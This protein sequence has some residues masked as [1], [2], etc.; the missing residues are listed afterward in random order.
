MVSRTWPLLQRLNKKNNLTFIKAIQG[1]VQRRMAIPKDGKLDFYS[2]AAG[3]DGLGEDTLRNSEL[4]A[5]AVFF[6]PAGKSGDEEQ[7]SPSNFSLIFAGGTT[8]S[9]A[10]SAIFFYLSR[11]S[12]VYSRLATEIRTTFSSGDEI[13]SGAQL[14]GCKYLRATIDET[15]RVAPPFTGTLVSIFS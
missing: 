11:D 7:L 5:E 13:K 4:W 14:S 10:L 1:I 8:L 15:L 2:I 12:N 3:D 9:A 6:L